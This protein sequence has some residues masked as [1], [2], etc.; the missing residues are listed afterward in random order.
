MRWLKE[1]TLPCIA[2]LSEVETNSNSQ[3]SVNIVTF[4]WCQKRAAACIIAMEAG[5]SLIYMLPFCV[6]HSYNV[7]SCGVKVNAHRKKNL[8]AFWGDVMSVFIHCF[9]DLWTTS[10]T[11]CLCNLCG[12]ALLLCFSNRC[13][14][15][16]L[17][18][19]NKPVVT[20]TGPLICFALVQLNWWAGGGDLQR[21]TQANQA[22]TTRRVHEALTI[23]KLNTTGDTTA[24]S[25][26][27]AN[28]VCCLNLIS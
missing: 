23:N 13:Y 24:L 12:T 3:R 2:L 8:L 22:T 10:F 27:Q 18:T 11:L 17:Y 6:L 9:F 1:S 7:L 4:D 25:R 20:V 14:V 28:Q 26:L 21:S 5:S 16:Q 15:C 19:I